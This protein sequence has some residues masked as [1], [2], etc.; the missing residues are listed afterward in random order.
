MACSGMPM[1]NMSQC[2]RFILMDRDFLNE[3][4]VKEINTENG[5]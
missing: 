3:T 2:H 4:K 5:Q 1:F